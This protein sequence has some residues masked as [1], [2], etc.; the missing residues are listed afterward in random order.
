MVITDPMTFV[1]ATFGLLVLVAIGMLVLFFRLNKTEAAPGQ[2]DEIVA[3]NHQLAEAGR[4]LTLAETR[5]EER[6]KSL[7]DQLAEKSA[8]L[9]KLSEQLGE[10]SA[11]IS[12]L[13]KQVATVSTDAKASMAA[14]DRI[15]KEL[16]EDREQMALR[17]KEMANEAIE[18][19]SKK[20]TET[21]AATLDARVKPV[22]QDL[23]SFKEAFEALKTE[24]LKERENL[25]VQVQTLT[26]QT[27][28]VSDQAESLTK[29]LRGDQKKQGNWGEM[30]LAN[31]L[32]ACGLVE[33]RD[34][35][36]E[37]SYQG[38][39]GRL[40]PDVIVRLPQQKNLVIDSKVNLVAF[41]RYQRAETDEEAKTAL[42][43]HTQAVLKHIRDLSSKEYQSAVPGTL[44]FVIL[45]MANEA[46][47]AAASGH[48]PAITAFAA[49][50]NI[51]I[52]T[53]S[54]LLMAL[55]T[56]SNIWLTEKRNRNAETIASRAGALYDKV[57]GFVQSFDR[58]GSQLETLEKTYQKAKT[59]LSEGSGNLLRQTEMLKELGA[60]TTKQLDDKYV[61]RAAENA[62]TP[63]L[64]TGLDT[65]AANEG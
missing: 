38:E 51:A 25:K 26:S 32:D 40:R 43:E 52:A 17:F 20:L 24:T 1:L 54:T 28:L 61:D 45:F 65:D 31:I 55:R 62:D 60:K 47:F 56:V 21:S 44:D 11:T 5:L 46:A 13:E 27:K 29:A 18:N 4:A 2:I 3:L 15:I 34:Y 41:E 49:E 10:K 16:R 48:D 36:R 7:T 35:D 33:G 63:P 39:D 50:R 23:K 42:Q 8:E 12:S 53:P 64:L 57:Y 22:A 14:S 58:V 59:Q 6:E 9:A 19:Q 37:Q 30:V